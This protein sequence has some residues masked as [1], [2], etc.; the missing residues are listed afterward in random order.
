M[1]E[2]IKVIIKY[3]GEPVGHMSLMDNTLKAFQSAVHGYI[4]TVQ[5]AASTLMICNEEGKNLPLTA[6]FRIK[7]GAYED[8]IFGTVVLVGTDGGEEFIDVPISLEAWGKM[9]KGW[10]N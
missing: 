5:I 3:P 1:T 7:E 2:K 4:E 6:N 8:V 9:L 10:G